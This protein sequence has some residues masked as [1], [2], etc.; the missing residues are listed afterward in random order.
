[1][2]SARHPPT[3][4]TAS[5]C[6]C[7]RNF[8]FF[9]HFDSAKHRPSSSRR[10]SC[11]RTKNGGNWTWSVEPQRNTT[12][13]PANFVLTRHLPSNLSLPPCPPDFCFHTP[14]ART[15][16]TR[17]HARTHTHARASSRRKLRRHDAEMGHRWSRIRMEHEN[18]EGKNHATISRRGHDNTG[19]RREPRGSPSRLRLT[20]LRAPRTRNSAQCNRTDHAVVTSATCLHYHRGPCTDVNL[21]QLRDSHIS[22]GE[23]KRTVKISGY[24][25]NNFAG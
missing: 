7:P 16:A 14:H 3:Q 24:I 17:T 4:A 20:A 13:S 9:R 15:H 11:F 2:G 23:R 19:S 21:R 1:M 12:Q 5:T 25:I 8:P 6:E 18:R 22:D 10:K